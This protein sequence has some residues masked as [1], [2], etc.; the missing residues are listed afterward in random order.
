[1]QPIYYAK[2]KLKLIKYMKNIFKKS[3]FLLSFIAAGVMAQA[4][5][6]YV[7]SGKCNVPLAAGMN[8]AKYQLFSWDGSE[9]VV[10]TDIEC[11]LNGTGGSY[12]NSLSLE[13]G[14][15][16]DVANY[17][18][19]SSSNR[20]MQALKLEAGKTLSV[21]LGGLTVSR[22]IAVGRA[23]SN[24]AL[25]IEIL[26]ET[27]E[28]NNKDFFVVDKEDEFSGS[29]DIVNTT[30]KEYNFFVYLVAG[31]GG[32]TP[33]PE[34]EPED[35]GE[36]VVTKCTFDNIVGEAEIREIDSFNGEIVAQIKF[37]SDRTNIVPQFEGTNLDNGWMPISA[38]FSE[39]ATQTFS[40]TYANSGNVKNYELTITEAEEEDPGD[41]PGVDPGAAHIFVVELSQFS[42]SDKTYEASFDDEVKAVRY[43]Y[44][45]IEVPAID[46][47]GTISF[48]GSS[49]KDDRFIYICENHGTT[50]SESRRI[51]MAKNY[52]A[53][54]AF[55]A[56]DIF[57]NSNKFYLV[58]TTTDDFKFKGAQ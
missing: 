38:D 34:P 39:N 45:G 27:I 31:E 36:P 3:V 57:I 25:S 43:D 11:N 5:E 21:S 10:T 41:D 1:M 7:V 9:T 12:Y 33:E 26:G 14:D 8:N 23:N 44:I 54:L 15:L 56:E 42:V 28:T 29:I 37:G 52:E 48:N 35:E 18:T 22:V 40:F 24:D 6:L 30:V 20:T 49:N 19:G 53:A 4:Q 50:K 13:I 46:A 32:E 55:T 2:M 51:V 58:F 16:T 17:S 47:G